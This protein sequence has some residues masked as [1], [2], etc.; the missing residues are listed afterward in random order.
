V[1]RLSVQVVLRDRTSTSPDCSAVKRSLALV[2]VN[3][4]LVRIAEDRSSDSAA[5]VDVE[6]GPFALVVRRG[7]AGET[8]VDAAHLRH[9][10]NADDRCA[11]R[12]DRRTRRVGRNDPVPS[13]LAAVTIPLLAF[14]SSGDHVLIV[15]SV[16]APTRNF[17]NTMLKRL[18]V[19]VEY[20]DPRSAPR[21]R[22]ADEAEHEGRVH[23]IAGLQHVR[24]AGHS[25]RSPRP[26]MPAARS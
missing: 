15:D 24:D 26:R 20:Y 22:G 7:E 14:L 12:G 2:G 25:R 3:F 9:Q 6:A 1:S 21:H 17:A 18:G 13:G 11:V 4:T 8:G 10:G 23:R 5:K 19:E 16:Y